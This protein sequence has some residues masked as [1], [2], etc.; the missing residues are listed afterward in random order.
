M[1]IKCIEYP[2]S[3]SLYPHFFKTW[4]IYKYYHLI[5]KFI[6]D[7][8][9]ETEAK[10]I[11]DKE[12]QLF[13]PDIIH[14]NVGPI[15]FG[16]KV[17]EKYQIHHVWHIREYPEIGLDRYIYPN[18]NNYLNMLHSPSTN[19][20]AITSGMFEYFS[21]SKIK[22][23][24]VYDGIFEDSVI[25]S[26]SASS[27]FNQKYFLYVATTLVESKGA[28]ETF[29]AFRIF[30]M[31]HKGYKL[32]FVCHYNTKDL[33]YLKIKKEI[34]KGNLYDNIVFL[35]KKDTNIVYNLMHH[36][37]AL[38][39]LSHF[40]GFGFTTAEA[41]YNRCLVIGRNTAGT[42]EQ[43]D[44]G[45]KYCGQEIGFRVNSIEETVKSMEKVSCLNKEEKI[46]IEDNAY[47]T[48]KRLYSINR[49]TKQVADIYYDI[50][51]SRGNYDKI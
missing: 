32:V 29:E 35:G 11:L 14:T 51:K 47:N 30:S 26:Y 12:V 27:P 38:L 31:K 6:K 40:E 46:K 25:P 8:I 33:L 15:F 23:K 13:R 22:D 10:K 2:F 39:M 16:F 21:L 1:N 3:V 18:R 37:E 28:L 36:A 43:F 34:E 9:R 24:I 44:N 50:L 5:K 49:Y 20:I 45:F 48:V 19:N 42:K 17:A 4:K 41:M 7:R